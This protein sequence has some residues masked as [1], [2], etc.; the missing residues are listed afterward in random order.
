M[1]FFFGFVFQCVVAIK[2]SNSVVSSGD[3]SS[4]L[5]GNGFWSNPISV[6]HT[7]RSLKQSW[8]CKFK[9]R[10]LFG[11]NSVGNGDSFLSLKLRQLG[12]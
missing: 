9:S 8:H 6:L 4:L 1:D 11:A 10:I 12:K 2:G 7:W 3:C 5:K